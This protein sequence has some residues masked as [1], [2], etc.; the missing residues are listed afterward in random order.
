[1]REVLRAAAT[2]SFIV[3]VVLMLVNPPSLSG[4]EDLITIILVAVAIVLVTAWIT[5]SLM[6]GGAEEERRYEQM[7]QRSES[8]ARGPAYAREADAFEALVSD[9]MDRLPAEFQEALSKIPVIV[10]FRGHEYRAYGHYHGDTIA[11]DNWADRITIYQ[12]TLV[13]DFGHDEE[14]L[15]AQVER[16]LR[17]ELAHHLGWGERGVRE[18]G[19]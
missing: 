13:R 18:L 6:G 15:R 4:A 19:L 7:V 17:H 12:D 5:V 14:L 2:A 10:S 9:A 8:L 1:M 11:R 16:T 3:G